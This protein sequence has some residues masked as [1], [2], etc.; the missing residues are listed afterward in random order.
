MFGNLFF[1][2]IGLISLFLGIKDKDFILIG[3]GLISILSAIS[4]FYYVK[5]GKVFAWKDKK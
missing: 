3:F 4:L 2:I 5:T 1:L